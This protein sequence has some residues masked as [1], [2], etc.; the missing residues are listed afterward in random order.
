[1]C[2]CIGSPFLKQLRVLL[3]SDEALEEEGPRVDLRSMVL[4]CQVDPSSMER[5]GA[6]ANL[7]SPS[8]SL[9]LSRPLSFPPFLSLSVPQISQFSVGEQCRCTYGFF[10][11]FLNFFFIFKLTFLLL[12]L[13]IKK[14]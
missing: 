2:G 12:F 7:S 13:L 5:S 1:M 11:F 9:F 10:F 8:R 14:S 3:E 4:N 6:T